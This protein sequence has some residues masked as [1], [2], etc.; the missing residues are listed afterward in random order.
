MAE[1]FGIVG[2]KNSG[3]TTLV[4]ALVREFTSRGLAVST[5]KHAHQGFQMD[6]PGTD[7]SAHAAAGAKEVAVVA[8]DK[9]A[10]IHHTPE[11]GASATLAT[12]LAKLA[13]C[14]IVLVEGF[15]N[16]PIPKLECIR[17]ESVSADQPSLWR[18]GKNVVAVATDH[19]I[20]G[21]S[22]PRFALDDVS[23]IANYISQSSGLGL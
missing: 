21:C 5:I 12:M 8:E 17:R 23:A 10:L 22:K 18:D 3:K 16:E 9:W 7:S 4:A 13:D 11:P 1:V 20:E 2:Y 14:H 19:E 15:K 6:H